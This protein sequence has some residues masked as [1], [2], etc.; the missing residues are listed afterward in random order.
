MFRALI[1]QMDTA[2][3]GSRPDNEI[4]FQLAAVTVIDQVDPWVNSRGAHL[5]IVRNIRTPFGRIIADEVIRNGLS[6]LQ[7]LE[8]ERRA[9]PFD[10]HPHYGLLDIRC[11]PPLSHI[12]FIL[13]PREHND[14]LAVRK[15]RD[16][17]GR[18]GEEP[19]L[20]IGLPEV[21]FENQRETP[22]HFCGWPL[23]KPRS[24][25]HC[26]FGFGWRASAF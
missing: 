24:R 21:W 16:H 26:G 2:R 19:N 7:S 23:R 22:K 1:S 14:V 6:F 5:A 10:L 18:P 17:S 11:F 9:S 3:V 8:T 25:R 4:V 13:A 12:R 15:K 20:R